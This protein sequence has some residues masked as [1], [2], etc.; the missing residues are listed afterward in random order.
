MNWMDW[1]GVFAN[2]MQ[3]ISFVPLAAAA[4]YFFVRSR[5]LDARL[6]ILAK[7]FSPRPAALAIGLKED[8]EGAVQQH[9]RDNHIV[10][11]VISITRSGM[12][13]ADEF[14]KILKQIKNIKQ[15][16][17]STG[18]TELNLFYDGPVTFAAAVGSMLHNWVP[19][20]VY[21]F[22]NG[23]YE[24]DLIIDQQTMIAPK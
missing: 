8:I 17:I 19:I 1:L 7:N 21:A 13:P 9:L 2:V 14:P 6:K 16:L 20:K 18:I 12:V 11:E 5:Q 24:L 3:V 15:K 10:M 22:R 4:V 23:H